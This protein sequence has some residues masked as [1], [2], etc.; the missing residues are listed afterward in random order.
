[1]TS[2]RTIL[3]IFS[4]PDDESM[5]P[6]ATLAK[7]AREGHRVLFVT[8]TEGGAGRLHA[9]RAET[10]DQK[11]RLK[12]V[13][14][15]ETEH[16]AQILGIEHLGYLG[17][18]DREVRHVDFLL[19][20]E[21]IVG[22]IRQTRPDVLMTFHGSGISYHPD[23][24]VMTH[25]TV[26][27]FWGAAHTDWY[28]DERLATLPPHRVQKLYAYVP[29]R[30]ATYWKN[31]PRTVYRAAGDEITTVIDTADTADLKWAAVRAHDSQKDGPP[32]RELYEAGAF[33]E[34]YFVRLF[35]TV[36]PGAPKETDLFEGLEAGNGGAPSH[37]LL[38]S[39]HA[40]R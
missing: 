3:C 15:S 23:H 28:T 11:R 13:R 35:P 27:A 7:Y 8:A 20:E 17:W 4:H 32:F 1:M 26:A 38:D 34:E 24:R 10:P 25:A 33:R 6:G 16:A 39:G 9:V 14:R 36:F 21:T 12:E 22:L 5:G 37:P 40:S 30:D 2:R 29:W 31:W 19:V 18:E